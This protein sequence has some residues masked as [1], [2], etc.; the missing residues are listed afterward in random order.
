[1]YWRYTKQQFL[2]L[3]LHNPVQTASQEIEKDNTLGPTQ[4]QSWI[5]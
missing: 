2:G 3:T 5:H 1:M 4:E